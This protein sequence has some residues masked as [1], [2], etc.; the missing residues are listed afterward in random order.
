MGKIWDKNLLSLNR[1]T[2]FK[3]QYLLYMCNVKWNRDGYILNFDKTNITNKRFVWLVF[4]Y[5]N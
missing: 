5:I 2:F 3:G 1:N 4:S